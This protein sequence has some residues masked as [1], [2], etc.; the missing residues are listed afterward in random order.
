MVVVVVLRSIYARTQL[1]VM[2]RQL[3]F[4]NTSTSERIRM[5]GWIDKII[6]KHSMTRSRTDG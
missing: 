2:S 1:C 5:D 3:F 6:D 4:C